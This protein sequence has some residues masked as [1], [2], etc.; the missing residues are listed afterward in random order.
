VRTLANESE[1]S[2]VWS[3]DRR[4]TFTYSGDST[5]GEIYAHGIR[6]LILSEIDLLRAYGA[7]DQ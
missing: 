5:P 7:P 2:K 6:Q 1:G 4:L 3:Y